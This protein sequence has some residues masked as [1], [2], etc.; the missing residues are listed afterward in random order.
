M[1]MHWVSCLVLLTTFL[2]AATWLAGQTLTPLP[3]ND[4]APPASDINQARTR[5]FVID[6]DRSTVLFSLLPGTFQSPLDGE[7]TIMFRDPSVPVNSVASVGISVRQAVFLA[8]EWAPP[9]N[10]LAEP[11]VLYL[12][13]TEHS[14]GW[15]NPRT[16]EIR[17]SLYLTDSCGG[18]P[19]PMP[20]RLQGTLTNGE[21]SVAGDNGPVVDGL[22]AVDI[23][24][25][26]AA[27][28][29][30][31]RFSTEVGFPVADST[32]VNGWVSDGDLLGERSCVVL[33]NRDLTANL[34]IMPV[35]PDLGLDA[36]T[37]TNYR[38]VMF[39]LEDS[40]WSETLGQIGHG[41][42]LCIT[43]QIV[44]TNAE[45]IMPFGSTS[46]VADVGL[47]A[48]HVVTGPLANVTSAACCDCWLLFSVEDRFY[49][50]A[51]N[52]W[53]GHGDLLCSCGHIFRTNWQLL[54]RF[55]PIAVPCLTSEDCPDFGPCGT[56]EEPGLADLVPCTSDTPDAFCID[57][58]LD[59]VTLTPRG[60]IWFSTERGFW[61]ANLG[62]ISDGDVLS[63][64][65]YVVR[66]NRQLVD[67][68]DPL[69]FCA[70][71]G[72]DALDR[73]FG[74]LLANTDDGPSLANDP[75]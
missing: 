52:R 28:N 59:A 62:W 22:M 69:V 32:G 58:G 40:V 16:G 12:D 3:V 11:M 41:D 72:L 61:D 18:P 46:S 45:L 60:E 24:A 14:Y 71:F 68:C 31:L 4:V 63:D 53:I 25:P 5:T 47:D 23:A 2:G 26:P 7:L 27:P 21:L 73:W 57:F 19:V 43:G 75:Q 36:A 9:N 39:S 51:L 66:R 38:P 49:S 35:V 48:A 8:I 6:G 37:L 34:G 10:I 30:E 56:N 44:R 33:R 15:Y 67:V 74:P 70:N 20:L 1:R 42:L 17:F 13:T 64:R 65:G 50:G 54:R 55:H 29:R